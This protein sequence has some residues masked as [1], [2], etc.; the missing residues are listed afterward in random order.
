VPTRSSR[1][2]RPGSPSSWDARSTRRLKLA[3][4]HIL[5]LAHGEV[6]AHVVN[7]D[8]IAHWRARR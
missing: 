3:L 1:S 6:P 5:A 8:A 2:G 4:D 7:A